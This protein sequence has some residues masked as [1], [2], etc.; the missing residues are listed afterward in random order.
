MDIVLCI[1][2]LRGFDLNRLVWALAVRFQTLRGFDLDRM[3]WALVVQ[4]RCLGVIPTVSC[5]FVKYTILQGVIQ[6]YRRT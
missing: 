1:Q 5:I 2:T 3:A 4:T 6:E